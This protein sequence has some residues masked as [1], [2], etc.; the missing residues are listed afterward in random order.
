M[1]VNSL[2]NKVLYLSHMIGEHDLS[3]VAVYETWLIPSVSSS[4]VSI[5]EFRVVRGDGA[6][7]VRKHG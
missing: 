1:N 3:V 5:D 2:V 7:L 6:L 4:F